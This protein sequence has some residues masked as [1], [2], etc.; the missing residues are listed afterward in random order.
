MRGVTAPEHPAERL[1]APRSPEVS[2]VI[3]CLNEA[4]SIEACVRAAHA[5]LVDGGYRGEVLVV[6][7][8]S[9]DGSGELAAQAGA[10]VIR[11]PRRGY[12]NAYLAGLAAARGTYIVMLDAD[13]TYDAAELPRF[14]EAL[15]Q[16]GDMAIGN[17][18]EN[19]KPGAMPWLHRHVGNPMLT[20]LLNRLFGTSV[21]DAHCGMRA[22]RR[23]VLPRLDLRTSGMELASEMVIRAAKA[24][25]AIRQFPIEYHPREGESKLST[26]SDGWRHLRFLLI[27]SPNHLFIAP[28]ATM[29]AVG[30]L[31]MA[32][33]LAN[34][35]FLGRQWD[36][37]AMIGGSLLLI[38]GVQVIAL[39]LCALA[40]GVYFMGERDEW[41]NRWR[42][43]LRLEHAL[44]IGGLIML[45]GV[46]TGGVLIGIWID[47]GFGNLAEERLAVLAATLVTVGVEV[48]FTSFLLSI[49]GLR[50]PD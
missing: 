20:G 28:G 34:V 40:Y 12:G 50:R 42:A 6:D 22:V 14:V 48:F 29:A 25:L 19:I 47:R 5:A 9:G 4:A 15:R 2:V 39:G 10:D 3:P 17:R 38:I 24:G 26:W 16:G 35:Q 33:V 23:D 8:G 44:A 37:H 30:A 21:K 13:M 49:L 18:M 43:R 11:E 41:F 1:A 27:H 7:N 36:I 31:V 32:A 46:V 45:A